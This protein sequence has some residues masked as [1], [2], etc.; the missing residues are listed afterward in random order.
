VLLAWKV[1][2]RETSVGI[3]GNTLGWSRAIEGKSPINKT[4]IGSLERKTVV[5]GGVK[6]LE[7]LSLNLGQVVRNY[8]D[9]GGSRTVSCTLDRRWD[10]ETG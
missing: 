1:R 10:R 6:P 7:H 3:G 2:P 8:F 4:P 9:N 5:R